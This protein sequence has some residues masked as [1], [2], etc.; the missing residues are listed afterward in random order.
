MLLDIDASR[1]LPRPPFV[2]TDE[3][4]I[5]NFRDIGGYPINGSPTHSFRRNLISRSSEPS[6]LTLKGEERV[7]SLGVQTIFDIRT[8][9][10]IAQGSGT[11]DN[12]DPDNP[13]LQFFAHP[14]K[15]IEGIERRHIDP[16]KADSPDDVKAQL[17]EFMQFP[18]F[19]VEV[20]P[21]HVS[22]FTATTQTDL[23]H[24]LAFRRQSQAYSISRRCVP[25]Y[26]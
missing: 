15:E 1:C 23:L 22:P 8:E 2:A 26:L 4:G 21:S 24:H 9:H 11:A 7:R 3:A 16:S 12:A 17:D 10:E 25:A 5:Y 18:K 20:C 19:T 14:A 13:K 6:A